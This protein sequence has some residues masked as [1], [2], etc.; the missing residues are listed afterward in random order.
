MVFIEVFTLSIVSDYSGF[1]PKLIQTVLNS[2]FMLMFYER[3][4]LFISLIL[5]FLLQKSLRGK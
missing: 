2:A 4:Q 5:T 3:I 1:T